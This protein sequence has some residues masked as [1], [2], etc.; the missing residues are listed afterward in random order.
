MKK[1]L[2]LLIVPLLIIGGN[3][4]A[5]SVLPAP[6]LTPASLF[7]FVDRLGEWLEE[8]LTFKP[9]SKIK[10]QMALAA[11]RVAEI[12]ILLDI[13][14]VEAK[15]LEV[16][17]N[18]LQEHIAE[19]SE[20]IEQEKQAGKDVGDLAGGAVD[21]FRIQKQEIKNAFKN[22][23]DDYLM[24][25]K[26]LHEELRAAVQSKDSEAEEEI[27]QALDDI[28][29][30]KEEAEIQKENALTALE[31]EKEQLLDDLSEEDLAEEQE[32]E[33]VEE[34]DEAEE[35]AIEQK[36]EAEEKQFEQ[37]IE[38]L[39][40]GKEKTDKSAALDKENEEINK[41]LREQEEKLS[42][43]DGMIDEILKLVE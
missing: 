41:E 19:T 23:K 11:E 6:G 30:A 31:A 4:K 26:Q 35:D 36:I 12:K 34:D 28:D 39:K 16:A 24:A 33:S 13:N 2:F 40:E 1:V 43:E 22:A 10:L 18:R 25:K 14:G 8:K 3:V 37:E 15:G 7:Y 17:Q 42:E 5:Q 27:L 32:F 20:M 38:Q 9:E 21:N 29:I